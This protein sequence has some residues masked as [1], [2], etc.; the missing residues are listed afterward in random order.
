MPE[1]QKQVDEM[2]ALAKGDERDRRELEQ[3][4][5]RST[6]SLANI[7]SEL[8]ENMALFLRVLSAPLPAESGKLL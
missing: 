4:Q 5:A 1:V 3:A 2:E 6:L 8:L 7:P